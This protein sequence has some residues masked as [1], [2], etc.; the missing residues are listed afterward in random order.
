MIVLLGVA[1][2]IWDLDWITKLAGQILAA[3]TARLAGRADHDA[4]DPGRRSRSLPPF[5]SLVTH[6][7]RR[8]CS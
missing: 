1:D 5:I 7:P 4:A 2:D 3:G 8:S 6:D